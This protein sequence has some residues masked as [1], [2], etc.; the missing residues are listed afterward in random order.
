MVIVLVFDGVLDDLKI[1]TLVLAAPFPAPLGELFR[2]IQETA[3]WASV[4]RLFIGKRFGHDGSVI[5]VVF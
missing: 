4:F 2:W 1:A 5:I 3:F